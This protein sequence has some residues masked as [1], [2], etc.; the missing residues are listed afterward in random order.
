MKKKRQSGILGSLSGKAEHVGD[1][2]SPVAKD[3]WEATRAA[4]A[5][6]DQEERPVKIRR[7]GV[8]FITNGN[9][10][11]VFTQPEN[12]GAEAL[13]PGGTVEE[14]EAPEEGVMREAWEE[15]GLEDLRLATSLGMY[16][17]EA[18]G[19]GELHHCY[20]YHLVCDGNPPERWIHEEKDPALDPEKKPIPFELFWAPLPDGVPPLGAGLGQMIPK[21][22]EVM[23]GREH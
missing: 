7:L 8:A 17:N 20:C 19:L 11:L 12:P 5:D 6:T 1:I 18:P 14:H 4:Q 13:V 10:L 16:E 23:A 9:R 15:T 3:E 2:I 22:L 21:L